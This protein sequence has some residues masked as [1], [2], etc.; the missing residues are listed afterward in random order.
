MVKAYLTNSACYMTGV[1]ANDTLPSNSQGMG[2]MNL[3]TAFDGIAHASPATRCPRTFF[4][5]TGEVRN[6]T[7]FVAVTG[8]PVRISL[9]WVDAPGPTSGSS[10]VN[11]LNLSVTIGANTYLGH[12]FT[13]AHS[14]TGGT[15][16]AVNNL[17]SVFLPAGIGAGTPILIT[18]TAANIAGEGVPGNADTTDQDYALVVYNA[19]PTAVAADPTTT[20]VTS[21]VNP[22]PKLQPVTFTST[23]LNATTSNPV[24]AGTVSFTD[25]ATAICSFVPVNGSGVATCTT[26]ALSAGPHTITANYNGDVG[27][28]GSNGTLNQTVTPIV[29]LAF[30]SAAVTG[31]NNRLDP[32]DCNALSVTVTNNGGATGT[33]VS[34]VLQQQHTGRQHQPAQLG[35]SGPRGGR[36]RQ[37]SDAVPGVHR[38]QH[39]RWIDRELHADVDLQRRRLSVGGQFQFAGRRGGQL[40]IHGNAIRRDHSGRRDSHSREQR[41]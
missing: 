40:C 9:A 11:N 2:M 4:G 35:L 12:V 6:H 15:A 41:G 5:A 8:Q 33:L 30:T 20:T 17:E 22:V 21:S 18:V 32:N 34:A 31:D 39:G 37:Q 26:S 3:G 14:V 25:G 23:T 29:E 1:S 38:Q 24:T 27:L 10:I 16:D 36:L 28:A 13:G 7:A 19:T